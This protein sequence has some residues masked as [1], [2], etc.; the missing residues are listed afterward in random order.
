MT[1]GVLFIFW[2]LLILAGLPQLRTEIVNYDPNSSGYARYTFASYIVYYTL[3]IIMFILSCFADL[4][5]K[6]SPYTYDRVTH[7]FFFKTSTNFKKGSTFLK[8]H[9]PYRH[10]LPRKDLVY[11][12]N[13]RLAGLIH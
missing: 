6:D 8:P 7:L 4:P 12:V 2:L 3:V 13:S 1:S 5:P 11:L 9:K 10:N